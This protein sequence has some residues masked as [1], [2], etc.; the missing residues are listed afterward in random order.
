[1]V[2]GRAGR[3]PAVDG[4]WWHA[5]PYRCHPMRRLTQLLRGDPPHWHGCSCS[6]FDG[7][8]KY[9]GYVQPDSLS[10]VGAGL[11]PWFPAH[12]WRSSETSGASSSVMTG[13][14]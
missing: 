7:G 9:A 3:S 8:G 4:L 5:S 10:A 12:Q 11:V 13:T 1:M 2:T 14:R 6:R